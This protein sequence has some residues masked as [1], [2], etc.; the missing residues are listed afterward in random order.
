MCIP[1]KSQLVMG[2]TRLQITKLPIVLY[3]TNIQALHYPLFH[4]DH[5]AFTEN[6]G[7]GKLKN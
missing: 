1:Y 5:S 2:G 6:K 3:T 4:E 7:G